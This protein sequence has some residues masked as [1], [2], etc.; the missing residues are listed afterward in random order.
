MSAHHCHAR[1]CS[2][3]VRPELLMCGLHWRMVPRPLQL[4]VYRTYR[5]G[6]CRDKKPSEEW[7]RAADAAIAAVAERE[8]RVPRLMTELDGAD[9]ARLERDVVERI[10]ILAAASSRLGGPSELRA[11]VLRDLVLP[12]V[13]LLAEFCTNVR[14]EDEPEV[15]Q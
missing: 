9:W 10:R 15:T 1:G 12:N 7:H 13:R 6:Q 14:I 5:E 3:L 8:G 2:V 4:E 11:K